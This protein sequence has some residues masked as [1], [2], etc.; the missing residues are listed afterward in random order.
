MKSTAY[1]MLLRNGGVYL[2]M[3]GHVHIR[4]T[5]NTQI[6]VNVFGIHPWSAE[7]T[8]CSHGIGLPLINIP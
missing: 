8:A 7:L 1:K 5:I 3:I 6:I 4:A 2:C